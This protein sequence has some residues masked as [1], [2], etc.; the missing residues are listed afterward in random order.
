MHTKS[1]LTRL[2]ITLTFAAYP[3]SLIAVEDTYI[4][5]LEARGYLSDSEDPLRFD[6]NFAASFEPEFRQSFNSGNTIAKFTLFGRWDSRDPNRRHGDIRELNV[7]H[8]SGSWETLTGISR[9]FWGVTESNH[10]VDIINQTN[11]LEGFD[12]EDKLGQAMI[13]LSRS[14]EQSTLTLF[15]LPGFRKRE[16]L[17]PDNPLALPVPI[18]NDS[19]LFDSSEGEDHVDYAIAV[20]STTD[21]PGSVAPPENLILYQVRM[22]ASCPFMP[23]SIN[24][25]WTFRLPATHGYGS[26]KRS[27]GSLITNLRE[28]ISPPQLA[29]SNTVYMAWR[30]DCMTW[31]C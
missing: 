13:R 20:S 25:A 4:F 27:A 31:V 6:D 19:P 2:I 22:A 21:Y 7:L 26:S 17:S 15:A 3:L 9:V 5:E 23:R 1:A 24:W 11:T 8:A 10:L 29:A 16:F 14:F 30:T 12:G 18:D 28:K